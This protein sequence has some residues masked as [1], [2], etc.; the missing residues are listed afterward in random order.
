MGVP[1]C[2]RLKGFWLWKG[3]RVSTAFAGLVLECGTGQVEPSSYRPGV[4]VWNGT[5]G[6][7]LFAGLV[8]LCGTGQ[9]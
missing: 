3:H 6:A 1:P 4:A 7:Q 8:L 5:G 2:S 9:G